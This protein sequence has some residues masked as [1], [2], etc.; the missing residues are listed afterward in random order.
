MCLYVFKSKLAVEYN[1]C[2]KNKTKRNTLK[3]PYLY[4]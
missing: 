4:E 3:F 1:S 2:K